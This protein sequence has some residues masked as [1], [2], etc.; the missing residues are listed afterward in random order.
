MR[1]LGLTNTAA[2]ARQ[3]TNVDREWLTQ[4]LL[5]YVPDSDEAQWVG[6]AGSWR[7]RP[8]PGSYAAIGFFVAAPLLQVS[9]VEMAVGL[10]YTVVRVQSET[11][12]LPGRTRRT[13]ACKSV[14]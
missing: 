14:V 5:E 3:G 12:R 2:A 10:P 13:D 11:Q 8:D 9:V 4:K 6:V 7:V 1:R